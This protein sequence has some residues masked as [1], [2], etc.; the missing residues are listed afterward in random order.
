VVCDV[1]QG[2]AIVLPLGAGRA[3][4]VDTG[5]EP[6]AV[7]RCLRDLGVGQVPLLVISHFHADH[8]GGVTG[9]FRA[10]RVAEVVTT[11]LAEP[12]EGRAK[13]LTAAALAGVPVAVP[14][15]GWTWADGPVRLTML[16]PVHR[17]G[18]TGSDVNN[19]SVVLI[20]SV[21]GYRLILTGDAQVEEQSDLLA[22]LG[23]GG[24]HADVLK[25]AHHGSAYQDVDFLDAVH[26]VLALVSVGVGNPYG[27]PNP[28]VLARLRRNGAR[29]LRT[30]LDGDLAAVVDGQGIGVVRRGVPAGAHPP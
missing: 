7:D 24:L 2:D 15:A 25:V 19:N 8:V 13:V 3:V 9:V 23:D 14:D 12:A 16:G 26:P 11:G 27:H 22:A 4:V 30:D 20:A 29:V 18:G 21:A 10:R 1:G 6:G 17:I 5:P 28:A